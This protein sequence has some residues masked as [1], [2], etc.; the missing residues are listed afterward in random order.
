MTSFVL[1]VTIILIALAQLYDV[2]QGMTHFEPESEDPVRRRV[3]V[4]FVTKTEAFVLS[5]H[6]DLC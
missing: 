5:F 3:C 1:S 6:S 2:I 4:A